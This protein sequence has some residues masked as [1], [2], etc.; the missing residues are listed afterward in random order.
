LWA[1]LA[2]YPIIALTAASQLGTEIDAHFAGQE[3]VLNLGAF[4]ANYW[5]SVLIL[6][7]IFVIA[8]FFVSILRNRLLPAPSRIVWAAAMALLGP[9]VAPAYWWRYSRA[10]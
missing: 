10:A 8:I 9:I 6:T 1:A 2:F 3:D 7:A 4:V 5:W